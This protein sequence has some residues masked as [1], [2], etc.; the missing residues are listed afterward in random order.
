MG[1]LCLF[2]LQSSHSKFLTIFHFYTYNKIIDKKKGDVYRFKN[3]YQKILAILLVVIQLFLI[4]PPMQSDALI[5]SQFNIGYTS[6]VGYT[7]MNIQYSNQ[8]V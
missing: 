7:I 4:I 8:S 6:S 5:D 2:I 3:K 1:L